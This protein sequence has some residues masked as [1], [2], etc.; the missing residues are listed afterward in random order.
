M[1]LLLIMSS[2]IGL[3]GVGDSITY[4]GNGSGANQPVSYFWQP[5]GVTSVP[6]TSI[7]NND[8][9]RWSWRVRATVN[10]K[11]VI[12]CNA[13]IGGTK[14][15]D[16]VSEF[17]THVQALLQKSQGNPPIST[18]ANGRPTRKYILSLMAGTNADTTNPNTHASN[19]ASYISTARA[20]GFD[21]VILCPLL[22]RTDG[23]WIG[24]PGSTTFDTTTVI[25]YNA[26]IVDST[27]MS[28]NGV[29]AVPRWDQEPLLC[30]AGAANNATYFQDTIHPTQS[31]ASLMY[32]Y[33]QTALNT[34]L[35][36]L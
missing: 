27:W 13:A 19:I 24:T 35:A 17:A 3:I 2:V 36:T 14:L 16:M 11:S 21:K 32:P 12:F 8:V 4:G 9:L 5:S 23:A 10:G 34:V 26:I 6:G 15:S 25:P 18:R 33:F 29:D 7:T 30:A 22:S 1:K 31:G 28:N 20:A